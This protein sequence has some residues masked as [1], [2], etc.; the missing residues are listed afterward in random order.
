M[1]ERAPNVALGHVRPHIRPALKERTI[2]AISSGL[3][4]RQHADVPVTRRVRRRG[5]VRVAADRGRRAPRSPR[6][7]GWPRRARSTRRRWSATGPSSPER[8]AASSTARYLAHSVYGYFLNGG[9]NCYV[10]RIGGRAGSGNGGG[11]QGDRRRPAGAARRLPGR[12][13]RR[14]RRRQG[15]DRASTIARRRGRAAARTCSSWWSRQGGQVVEE[16]DRLT[17][18]RGKAERRHR[19]QRRLEADPASRRPP[20][21]RPSRRPAPGRA[22]RLRRAAAARRRARRRGCPP[23]TT[24]ATSPTAPASAA[25]RPSTRSPW[26]AS[27]T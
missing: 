14:R 3:P 9:G 8:S 4:R 19:G 24:S 17:T 15:S 18:G 1:P 25:S 26:S 27:P 10:V 16:Y 23:T 21:A 5:R 22:S 20:A 11:R 6:S 2:T 7:S 12:R 13:A